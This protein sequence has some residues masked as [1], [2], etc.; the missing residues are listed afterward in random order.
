[1]ATWGPPSASWPLCSSPTSSA[2]LRSPSQE[3]PERTRV[4]LERF[5]DAMADEIEPRRRERSRSSPAT[6]SWRSFGVP[7]ALEDH[8]ERALHAALAMQR[9]PR[10]RSSTGGSSFAI[11]VNTGEVVVGQA[12]RGQ[13][14]RHRRRGQRCRPA[15]AGGRARRD[16]SSAPAR[17]RRCAAPSSSGA[18][19]RDRREG[20]SRAGHGADARARS[21]ADAPARRAVAGARAFVGRGTELELLQAIYRARGRAGRAARRHARWATRGSARRRWCGSSGGGSRIRSRSRFSAPAAAWPTATHHVLGA[22][23][24]CFEEHLGI[25]ESESPEEVRR[26]LGDREILGLAL[27]LDLTGD[28]A[29]AR[30]ARPLPGGLGRVPR[31][32]SRRQRRP[33]CSSRTCTGPRIRCST[34]SSGSAMRCAVRCS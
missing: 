4:L 16:P 7:A 2:R 9:A 20:Q 19:I 27:G 23:R 25:L 29:P 34:C 12:A 28:A 18:G 31:A 33:S 21:D 15:R 10:E 32:S 8:A 13:L 22:R 26:R 24:R 6:P 3:D 30:S 17:P 14:L 1:M 5:Y 11:G